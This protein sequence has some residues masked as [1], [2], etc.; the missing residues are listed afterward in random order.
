MNSLKYIYVAGSI[1]DAS[2]IKALGNV[3]VGI[4]KSIE[5]LV[6]WELIPFCPFIDFLFFLQTKHKITDKMIKDYSM[7]WLERCDCV[8]VLPNSSN[9]IGTQAEIRRAGELDIPVFY[10]LEDLLTEAD[11]LFKTW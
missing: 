1:S 10:S 2:F 11:I 3:S 6:E 4:E 9:S 8:Y 7:A 5:L